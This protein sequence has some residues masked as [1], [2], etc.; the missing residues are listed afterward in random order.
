LSKCVLR[1]LSFVVLVAS[2]R[3]VSESR[4]L[5][6]KPVSTPMAGRHGAWCTTGTVGWIGFDARPRVVLLFCSIAVVLLRNH[7]PMP[8]PTPT[9]GSRYNKTKEQPGV[10]RRS[11]SI[12]PCRLYTKHRACLPSAW[13]PV[14]ERDDETRK[15]IVR[16]R[17]E[18]QKTNTATHTYS[19][20]KL[21]VWEGERVVRGRC[22][23]RRTSCSHARKGSDHV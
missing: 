18:Q 10:L 17:Q 8:T 7:Q 5:V 22:A 11:R 15:Q 6:L 12:R 2:A 23:F 20:T 3:F 1:Y 9:N 4:R 14:W 13:T 21:C 19:N 16:T